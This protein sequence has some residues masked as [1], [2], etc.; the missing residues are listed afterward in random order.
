V[1]IGAGDAGEKILRE[2]RDNTELH[3]RV[4]GFID[5]DRSK[6]GRTI[7]DVRVLGELDDMPDIVEKEAIQEALI[8][9]PSGTGE[10]K[11]RIIE[12]CKACGLS[13]KTLPGIGELIDGRV[14]VKALRDVN[15]EDLLGRPPVILQDDHIREYLKDNVVMVTGAGGSIGSELCRQILRYSP[16]RIVLVDSAEPSLY[17]IKMDLQQYV[18]DID[19]VAVL[20]TVQD[21]SIMERTLEKHR[22]HVVFHAAAY[23]HVPMLER[24]PWQAVWNNIRGTQT[25]MEVSVNYGVDR[26]ILV[27]TD[28]AV[29]PSNIM[30][31]SKRCC[32]LLMYAYTGGHT[33]R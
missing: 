26:F 7:H 5:D 31:A 28:K 3:Y 15:Y 9:I 27:S 20:A 13:F 22:P 6:I 23:K 19:Y 25:L 30:G 21:R 17:Q 4:K 1:I 2:I 32:E 8:A 14:S 33:R 11:R 16:R 24:N 29:R 12:I 10:E 18:P